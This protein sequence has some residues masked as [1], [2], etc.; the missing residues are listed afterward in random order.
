MGV[1]DGFEREG[2]LRFATLFVGA[3]LGLMAWGSE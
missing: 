1:R 3:W 2:L